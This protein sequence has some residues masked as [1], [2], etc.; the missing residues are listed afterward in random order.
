MD[1]LNCS[2]HLPPRTGRGPKARYCSTKCR[3]ARRHATRYILKELTTSPCSVCGMPFQHKYKNSRFC[4][5]HCRSMS[6]AA[7][8]NCLKC[9]IEFRS[10][11]GA[12]HCSNTCRMKNVECECQACGKRYLPKVAGR[13]SFCSRDC[14]FAYLRWKGEDSRTADE[15]RRAT[16]VWCVV[17]YQMFDPKHRQTICSDDCRMELARR[18]GVEYSRKKNPLRAACIK[19]ARAIDPT[20][21]KRVCEVCLKE[22]DRKHGRIAKHV[23][24]ARIKRVTFESFDPKDI[25]I[26]DGYRCWICDR[27]TDKDAHPESDFYP[28]VDHVVPLALGGSHTPE[29]TRCAHRICNSIKRDVLVCLKEDAHVGAM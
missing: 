12:K 19:C 10:P 5:S 2:N 6:T 18:K 21:Q 13:N 15:K 1:C 16:P 29:N 11:T 20:P 27:I 9:G 4:S 26:R 8:A 14:S 17:C 28:S 3:A 22:S 24:R 7:K 25:L 23:R